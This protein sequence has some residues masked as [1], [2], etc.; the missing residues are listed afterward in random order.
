MFVYKNAVLS[1]KNGSHLWLK[2]GDYMKKTTALILL[3]TLLSIALF[4]CTDIP[5]DE[6]NI[7]YSGS[8]GYTY[9][10]YNYASIDFRAGD[11]HVFATEDFT[12]KNGDELFYAT[13]FIT[14]T[15]EST[16][17]VGSEEKTVTLCT[18]SDHA[19]TRAKALSEIKVV[20]DT[21]ITDECV[22]YYLDTP[23][24]ENPELKQNEGISLFVV[25]T[26][27]F[28]LI[29]VIAFVA[30]TLDKLKAK[31]KWWRIPEKVLLLLSFFGGGIGGYLAMN[32]FRHK[33]TKKLFH[34][35]NIIGIVWQ[36]GL[37]VL[38]AIKGI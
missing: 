26:I 17:T 29:S 7:G 21:K 36:V 11:D 31:L 15:R 23:L 19:F 4:S 33:T 8:H 32:L 12:M 25:M 13:G 14:K 35:V 1:S 24:S 22:I 30:Y 18:V 3:I 27:V 28:A 10:G 38:L 20:F 16:V 6:F 34:F 37:L 5:E 9:D 2:N